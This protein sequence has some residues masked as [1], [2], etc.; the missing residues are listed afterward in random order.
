[1]TLSLAQYVQQYGAQAEQIQNA[2]GV[3]AATMLAI[4]YN[5]GGADPNTIAGGLYPGQYA[6]FG[7][8]GSGGNAG[9][10]TIPSNEVINGVNTMV[11]STFN[12]YS[13]FASAA[14]GFVQFLQNNSRY[15]TALANVSNPQTFIADLGAA[16]YATSP[17]WVSQIQTLQQ[18]ISGQLP[19]NDGST[20]PPSDN[21]AVALASS[22]QLVS[23]QSSSSTTA[24]ASSSGGG[25]F[26]LVPGVSGP[27]FNWPGIKISTGFLWS[28]GFF[29]LAGLLIVVGLLVYFHKQVEQVVGTVAKD[30]GA[31]V[32]AA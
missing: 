8:K 18:Q 26:T 28:A 12:A 17:T 24:A 15:G 29:L 20:Q 2:T 21:N 27:G 7:V 4:S 32:V 3:D 31:A 22:A 11:T 1:M 14:Q 6:F 25:Q 13:N 16:G 10:I 30:A 23:S 19:A 5:E 9:T